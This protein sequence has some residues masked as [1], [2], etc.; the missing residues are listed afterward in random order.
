M[1]DLGI[2]GPVND[3]S[4]LR[5]ILDNV[6]VIQCFYNFNS[7]VSKIIYMSVNTLQTMTEGASRKAKK[8]GKNLLRGLKPLELR[9]L[10]WPRWLR[11]GAIRHLFRKSTSSAAKPN[12]LL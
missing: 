6:E 2:S 9:W 10:R 8:E 5:L 3:I 7:M 1:T 12:A 4:S 11:A